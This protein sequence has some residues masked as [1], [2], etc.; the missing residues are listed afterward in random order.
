MSKVY[1]VYKSPNLLHVQKHLQILYS[2]LSLLYSRYS[3]SKFFED[4]NLFRKFLLNN[5]FGEWDYNVHNVTG[6][7][8]SIKREDVDLTKT[9]NNITIGARDYQN[10]IAFDKNDN[11]LGAFET[12]AASNGDT[13]ANMYV[14]NYNTSGE[15]IANQPQVRLTYT[16]EGVRTFDLWDFD[17][18]RFNDHH[19][20][21]IVPVTGSSMSLKSSSQF[22]LTAPNQ[23]G[24]TF[25][26]WLGC[27]FD[28]WAGIASPTYPTAQTSNWYL[29]KFSGSEDNTTHTVTPRAYALYI[30]NG[31]AWK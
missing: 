27:V 4:V 5:N 2:F 3:I 8:H 9:D 15:K 6:K 31:L 25:Q 24:Y 11:I 13:A 23:D 18:I 17:D 20:V 21:I 22:S 12:F 28:G 14:V 7:Y 10:F 16:K 1:Y 26:Y 30:Q 29:I 19:S